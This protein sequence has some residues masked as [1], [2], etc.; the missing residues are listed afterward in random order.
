MIK[1]APMISR[2]LVAVVLMVLTA[3]CMVVEETRLKDTDVAVSRRVAVGF[4]YLRL[5]RPNDA[6]RHISKAL[7]HDPRSAEAHNAMAL[8]YQYEGDLK[9][10]EEHFRRSLRYDKQYSLARNNYGALLMRQER[11]R[12]ALAQFDQ[13]AS[14]PSYDNRAI[15]FENKGR[16]LVALN[17]TDEALEAFNISLRIDSRNP[18]PLIEMAWVHFGLGQFE[19]AERAYTAYRNSAEEPSAR[20]LW[21]G[22]RLAARKNDRE[23]IKKLEADLEKNYP[24][25]AEFRQ[26]R[27]WVNAGRPS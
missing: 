16:A 10:A 2:S 7:E 26:W 24:T 12:D 25:S 6:R 1:S 11:Y 9:R 5:G 15:A 27:Q 19:A 17:R 14:D 23:Q 3:G 22:I 18:E 20:G 8:L 21:L 4:E 13:A